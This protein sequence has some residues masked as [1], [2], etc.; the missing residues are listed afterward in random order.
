VRP[1][2]AR[3]LRL[4]GQAPALLQRH[5]HHHHVMEADLVF[6]VKPGKLDSSPRL[7][8]RQKQEGALGGCRLLDDRPGIA[9]P[10]LSRAARRRVGRARSRAGTHSPSLEKSIGP[11]SS[12]PAGAK[13]SRHRDR[14]RDPRQC[15][16]RPVWSPTPL[17][18]H[19]TLELIDGALSP[20]RG[21]FPTPRPPGSKSTR[22]E[23]TPTQ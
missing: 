17:S 3:H 12:L 23:H 8:A 9:R 7:L 1:R 22:S 6:I 13:L 10:L 18:P 14:D 20:S 15:G 2:C 11:W 4:V 21:H 16:L 5:R 19:R